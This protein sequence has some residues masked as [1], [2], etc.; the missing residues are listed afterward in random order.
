MIHWAGFSTLYRVC[1]SEERQ[2]K[3]HSTSLSLTLF[4]GW[5]VIRL[6]IISTENEI[7]NKVTKST[8]LCVKTFFVSFYIYFLKL[9]VYLLWPVRETAVEVSWLIPCHPVSTHT[10]FDYSIFTTNSIKAI[11]WICE[12]FVMFSFLDCRGS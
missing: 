10:H 9:H 4:C 11:L 3:I 8:N 2:L 12:W 7:H 6:S 5:N 1:V